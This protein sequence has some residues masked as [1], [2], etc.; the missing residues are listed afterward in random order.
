MYRVNALSLCICLAY[1]FLQ[2]RESI[3]ECEC[4]AATYIPVDCSGQVDSGALPARQRDAAL[5]D[6]REVAVRELLEVWAEAACAAHLPEC[7]KVAERRTVEGRTVVRS[8]NVLDV[9][10]HIREETAYANICVCIFI[11]V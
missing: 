7:S 10:Q 4:K 5:A 11:D 6:Q 8:I 2:N 3:V 9:S 1:I